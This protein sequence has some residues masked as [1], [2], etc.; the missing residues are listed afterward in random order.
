MGRWTKNAN[1]PQKKMIIS[2]ELFE[3][4]ERRLGIE[5]KAENFTSTS[6]YGVPSFVFICDLARSDRKG[7]FQP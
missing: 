2:T 3:Q 6:G 1:A 7:F 4:S 5:D